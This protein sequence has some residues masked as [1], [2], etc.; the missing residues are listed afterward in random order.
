[1][2]INLLYKGVLVAATL[3]VAPAALPASSRASQPGARH[4]GV[5]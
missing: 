4:G 3:C 1:M 2:R 5:R